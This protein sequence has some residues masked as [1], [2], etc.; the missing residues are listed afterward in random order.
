MQVIFYEFDVI[1]DEK[2]NFAVILTQYNDQWIYVKHKERQTW[3]I[4]GGRREP[5]E[6]IENTARRELYEETG[7]LTYNLS[8]LC[9]YS[10]KRGIDDESY[11]ALYY[12]EVLE[13]GPLPSVSE[14]GEIRIMQG[15]PSELTYPA[16]QPELYNKG[17]D[18]LYF[19]ENK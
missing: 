9:V 15:L 4:P 19:R 14:I 2:L 13:L 6:S 11:G 8:P 1:D 16:I 17:L 18:K 12:S 3:E 5:N 10:V 7:A